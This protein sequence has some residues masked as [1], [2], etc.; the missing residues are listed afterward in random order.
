[1]K[2]HTTEALTSS[3]IPRRSTRTAQPSP[4]LSAAETSAL[5]HASLDSR[6]RR[7][8]Q[9]DLMTTDEAAALLGTSRVTVNAWIN[10]GRCIGLTQTKRGF[11]VPRWQFEPVIWDHLPGIGQ[12]L[13]LHEG[14]AL[15]NFF[16]TPHGGLE[17]L[18][19]RQALEQGQAERVLAVARA[20]GA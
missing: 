19:P 5:L 10:K 4:Y 20:E 12:A 17:G 11:K 15:L 1:M 2:P 14:W 6:L 13:G 9:A 8:D 16:E 7:L 3:A 18:T